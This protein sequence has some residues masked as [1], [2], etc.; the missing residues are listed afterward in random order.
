MLG[1][2]QG[3]VAVTDPGHPLKRLADLD[4]PVDPIRDGG[5]KPGHHRG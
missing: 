2:L 3:K 4:I 5:E 1:V